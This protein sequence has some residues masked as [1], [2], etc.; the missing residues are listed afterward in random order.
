MPSMFS[1][2]H[3]I[4]L[5]TPE[6]TREYLNREARDLNDSGNTTPQLNRARRSLLR[7]P[8][9]IV[10]KMLRNLRATTGS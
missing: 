10:M 5:E 9:Y 2:F 8:L 7:T 4:E 6:P 3:G 1:C